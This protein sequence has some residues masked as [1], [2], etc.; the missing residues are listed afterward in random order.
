MPIYPAGLKVQ[1]K[2]AEDDPLNARTRVKRAKCLLARGS[3][4][5][6]SLRPKNAK[7]HAVAMDQT[8]R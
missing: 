8:V 2:F 7:P 5:S 1:K 3:E 6:L 4:Q